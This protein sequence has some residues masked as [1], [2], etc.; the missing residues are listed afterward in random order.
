MKSVLLVL[1]CLTGFIFTKELYIS[2]TRGDDNNSGSFSH[3][4]KT[5]EKAFKTAEDDDIVKVEEGTYTTDRTLFVK[6]S[7]QLIGIKNENGKK[8]RI[9]G[10]IAFSDT[11]KVFITGFQF[12]SRISLYAELKS[13]HIE[14][15]DFLNIRGFF[16]FFFLSNVFL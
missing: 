15:C 8:P 10:R 13:Y 3:P 9:T 6:K 2:E 11:K 12:E 5:L 4:F 16:F 1:L 7:F 14:H